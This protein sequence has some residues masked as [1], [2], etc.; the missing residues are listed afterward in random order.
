MKA[1]ILDGFGGREV[2]GIGEIETPTIKPGQVL[3][4]VE[5]TSINRADITQRQGNYPAPPGES[6]ILGLEA[7]GIVEAVGPGVDGWKKGDRVMSLVAGGGYAEYAAAYAEHLIPIPES[8]SFEEAACISEVYITAFLNIFRIGGLKDT[9]TVL[10]HGAT[11]GIGTAAMQLCKMLTPDAKIFV[12]ASSGKVE[13]VKEMGADLA[14]NYKEEDFTERV[15]EYTDQKGVDL[16][17]D[18]IGAGYLTRNMN[19]LAIG[20]RLVV[21][22]VLGGTTAEINLA[23]LMV[24]RQRIIG[25][26]LRARPV[27]EKGDIVS[28]FI[29]AVLPRLADRTIGP[30][31]FKTLPLEDVAEAH[32]IMEDNRHFGNIVLKIR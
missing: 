14:I 3:I 11:G 24:K 29:K 12:T 21:I 5:A 18:H 26:V 27:K 4:K 10:I 23:S 20:G 28:H 6:E 9:E 13:R 15:Q 30:V 17:L 1:V 25:S 7:A 16:I 2:L 32:R 8:I 22:G 31:I 19:A